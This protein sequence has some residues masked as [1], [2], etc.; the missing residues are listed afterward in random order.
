[1]CV[2]AVCAGGVQQEVP[3][4]GIEGMMN[5]CWD[6]ARSQ[7]LLVDSSGQVLEFEVYETRSVGGFGKQ[8]L[9]PKT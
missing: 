8:N 1:M 2:F 3:V 4:A 6:E 5:V 7:L 9:E